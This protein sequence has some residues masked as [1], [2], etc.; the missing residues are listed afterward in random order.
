MYHHFREYK[1]NP[2]WMLPD[3]SALHNVPRMRIGTRPLSSTCPSP[4][5]RRSSLEENAEVWQRAV[6]EKDA[7]VYMPPLPNIDW[8][9]INVTL[10]DKEVSM[11]PLKP[12][13]P[14]SDVQV[15]EESVEG[16]PTWLYLPKD[17]TKRY[18]DRLGDIQGNITS[19][20]WN[21]G[22]KKWLRVKTRLYELGTPPR[23]PLSS[24][25]IPD[26]PGC[27]SPKPGCSYKERI[28]SL[29]SSV[30][31]ELETGVEP[32]FSVSN[33]EIPVTAAIRTCCWSPAKRISLPQK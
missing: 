13:V 16:F 19:N 7:M 22:Q 12:M 28:P 4:W 15:L 33:C 24:R 11:D 21:L 18:R 2:D 29:S 23:D 30:I 10:L 14:M 32:Q 20:C 1:V 6:A 8:D 26:F 31:V 5:T 9:Q 17:A 27:E 25:I 3:F